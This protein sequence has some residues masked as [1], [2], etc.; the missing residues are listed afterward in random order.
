MEG[1]LAGVVEGCGVAR[2]QAVRLRGR[3]LQ[4]N[5]D[6]E[7][8]AGAGCVAGPRGDDAGLERGGPVAVAAAR[9]GRGATAFADRFADRGNGVPAAAEVGQGLALR[10]AGLRVKREVVERVAGIGDL[11][12]AVAALARA[13]QLAV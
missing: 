10:L 3:G 4:R 7:R 11:Q 9:P 1:R 12:P 13:E 6:A 5:L 2:Q 8:A